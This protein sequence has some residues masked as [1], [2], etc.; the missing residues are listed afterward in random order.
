[1]CYTP[2]GIME[3]PNIVHFGIFHTRTSTF[4][5]SPN[6]ISNSIDVMLLELFISSLT[7]RRRR[8]TKPK[9][10]KNHKSLRTHIDFEFHCNLHSANTPNYIRNDKITTKW[11]EYFNHPIR[12]KSQRFKA[13]S[14]SPSPFCLLIVIIVLRLVI[15]FFISIYNSLAN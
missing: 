2:T 14:I 9:K 4:R 3:I 10:K 1:M 12:L 6:S 13:I 15:F 11:L 5:L 8:L 7:S